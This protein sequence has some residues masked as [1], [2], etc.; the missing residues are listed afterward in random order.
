M[1]PEAPPATRVS[2]LP[3]RRRG[4]LNKPRI[5]LKGN[6]RRKAKGSPVWMARRLGLVNNAAP[7]GTCSASSLAAAF[8]LRLA[9]LGQRRINVLAEASCGFAVPN[10]PNRAHR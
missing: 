2:G 6:P 3:I 10:Q 4:Q 9:E 8:G 1:F 5:D 7:T